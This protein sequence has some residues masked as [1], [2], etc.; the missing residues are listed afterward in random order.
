MQRPANLHA[1]SLETAVALLALAMRESHGPV[2]V[3][4]CALERMARALTICTRALDREA[5]SEPEP[6]GAR[7]WLARRDIEQLRDA[8]EREITVCIENLQFHDRMMQRLADVRGC[9]RGLLDDPERA[10]GEAREPPRS[11]LACGSIELF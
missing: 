6:A 2:D 4:G 7:E 3:L 1:Q 9:L 5:G 10:A 11:E 8:L